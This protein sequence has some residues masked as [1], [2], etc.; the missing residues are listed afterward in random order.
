MATAVGT[1]AAHFGAKLPN[2]ANRSEMLGT[3]RSLVSLQDSLLPTLRDASHANPA[4]T[5][6]SVE[7]W[8]LT[9]LIR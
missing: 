5:K 8:K 1:E 2:P 7:Y 4:G 9:S 3:T 6:P